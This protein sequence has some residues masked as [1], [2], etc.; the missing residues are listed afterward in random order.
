LI[1]VHLSAFLLPPPLPLLVASRPFLN[2]AI[3]VR[4]P[5]LRRSEWQNLFSLHLKVFLRN[6]LPVFFLPFF[7]VTHIFWMPD[8]LR[9][10]GLLEPAS[11]FLDFYYF[12]RAGLGLF[13]ALLC[14][15]FSF[16]LF[17]PRLCLC[18]SSMVF[19]FPVFFEAFPARHYKR[20][21]H[22]LPA[23]VF[24]CLPCLFFYTLFRCW[25]IS[26]K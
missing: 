14:P 3:G 6:S 5:A 22:C 10:R 19:L 4:P 18:L 17:F 25:K 24:A 20:F 21:Q 16:R 11:Q 15:F 13:S 26:G 1:A 12:Q 8:S 2:L 23:S 9:R 7:F